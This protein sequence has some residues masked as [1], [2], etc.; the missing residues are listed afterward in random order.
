MD[1]DILTIDRKR[2]EAYLD[3]YREWDKDHDSLVLTKELDVWWYALNVEEQHVAWL[4]LAI[5]R[6]GRDYH[7]DGGKE[8]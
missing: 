2:V 1:D 6:L 4:R 7:A 8:G 3:C 5:E